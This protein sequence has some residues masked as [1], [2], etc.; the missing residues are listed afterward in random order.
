MK[1]VI[2]FIAAVF[3]S[4]S[5]LA[6]NSKNEKREVVLEKI[7]SDG[8][9][10][11]KKVLPVSITVGFNVCGICMEFTLTGT[12]AEINNTITQLN[13]MFSLAECGGYSY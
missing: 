4:F 11:H 5:V 1:K 6:A 2:G 10:I 9:K 8:G 12:W 13:Y 7:F 3:F